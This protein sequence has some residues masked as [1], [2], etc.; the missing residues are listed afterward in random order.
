MEKTFGQRIKF[1]LPGSLSWNNIVVTIDL[2]GCF[3][4][5]DTPHDLFILICVAIQETVAVNLLT[6]KLVPMFIQKNE[7]FTNNFHRNSNDL[8][9]HE[10]SNPLVGTPTFH[11]RKIAAVKTGHFIGHD[12]SPFLKS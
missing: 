6:N 4:Y 12:R 3:S 5:S 9:I 8:N 1:S 2:V 11:G 7:V 10:S